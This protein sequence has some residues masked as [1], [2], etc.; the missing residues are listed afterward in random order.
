MTHADFGPLQVVEEQLWL[1]LQGLASKPLRTLMN[2]FPVALNI[3]L[4][5]CQRASGPA[6]LPAVEHQT[7]KGH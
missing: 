1:F 4:T 7:A 2:G 3:K 6:N 5:P